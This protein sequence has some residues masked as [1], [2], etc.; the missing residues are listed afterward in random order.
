MWGAASGCQPALA[1]GCGCGMLWA[2]GGPSALPCSAAISLSAAERPL[3][4]PPARPLRA[5]AAGLAAVPKAPGAAPEARSPGGGG[6]GGGAP[7]QGGGGAASQGGGGAASRPGSCASAR[8]SAGSGGPDA[9]RAA[10]SRR[11]T[12]EPPSGDPPSGL[13]PLG[14]LSA[15]AD[16]PATASLADV[17]VAMG[18]L[19]WPVT[20]P[21]PTLWCGSRARPAQGRCAAEGDGS[22]GWRAKGESAPA[23][24]RA[25]RVSG[26][27]RKHAAT[28]GRPGCG[29]TL[30]TSWPSSDARSRGR[31]TWLPCT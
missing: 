26:H 8:C 3:G 17:D 21:W 27:M 30:Q 18:L 9:R 20:P 2:G 5:A 4:G 16:Q 31:D 29:L 19:T 23:R 28:T 15:P 1:G 22:G 24:Q 10:L 7:S 13:V 14:T 11:N 12:G 25:R 6:G